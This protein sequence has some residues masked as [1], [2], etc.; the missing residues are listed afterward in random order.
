MLKV[1]VSRGTLFALWFFD[2][3]S[4]GRERMPADQAIIIQFGEARKFFVFN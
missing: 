2:T 1:V 3:S 4:V